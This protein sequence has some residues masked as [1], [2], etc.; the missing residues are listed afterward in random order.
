MAAMVKNLVYHSE[1]INIHHHFIW[2]QAAN[3]NIESVHISTQDW[4]VDNF[5]KLLPPEIF[6][7]CREDLVSLIWPYKDVSKVWPN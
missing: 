5:S 3:D 7:W 6:I 2:D 1:Y 4:L